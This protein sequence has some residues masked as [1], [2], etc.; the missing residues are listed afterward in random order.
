LALEQ[1]TESEKRFLIDLQMNPI[2]RPLLEKITNHARELPRY[3]P[4]QGGAREQ[5]LD[6][7]Y[8]SGVDWM[9]AELLKLLRNE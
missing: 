3:K 5:E 2:W 1:L 8:Y 4:G 6:W 9:R 7:I